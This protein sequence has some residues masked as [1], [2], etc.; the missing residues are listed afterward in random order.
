MCKR[1]LLLIVACLLAATLL[2]MWGVSRAG[3]GTLNLA[4]VDQ[5]TDKTGCHSVLLLVTNDGPYRICYPDGFF[6]QTRTAAGGAYVPTTNLWLN[7]GDNATILVA[8]PAITTDWCGVVS[9]YA[10]SPWNRMK[11]RLS[12]SPI[13]QRLP[14]AFSTVRGAEVKSQWMRK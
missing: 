14:S 10:E 7:P 11:M 12:S 6:V 1:K 3:V 9:Y 4:I 13:G 2:A 8:L 5:G